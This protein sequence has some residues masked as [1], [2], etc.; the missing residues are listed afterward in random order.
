MTHDPKPRSGLPQPRTLERRLL[1]SAEFGRLRSVPPAAEWF[2]NIESPGTRRIYQ[3]DIGDFMGFTGIRD[4]EEFRLITRAHVIAFRDELKRRGLQGATIR[5]KLAALSSLYE[6]LCDRNAVVSNPVKGVGR[7]KVDSY[8]GKT[9]A[10]SD[11]Q[12]RALLAAPVGNSLKA[13]R[14]RALLSLA[15]E[16]ARTGPDAIDSWNS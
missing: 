15:P 16:F 8:Q 2:A 5:R 7:P 9:P 12:V 3:I 10:L 14:D 13:K 4:P 11:A 6:Y 1:T